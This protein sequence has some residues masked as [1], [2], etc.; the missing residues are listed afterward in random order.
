M[1]EDHGAEVQGD[2]INVGDEL[3][4]NLKENKSMNWQFVSKKRAIKEVEYGNYY[5]VIVIPEDFSE[6]LASVER[7][8]KKQQWNTM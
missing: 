8:P 3:V 1:N 2:A 5:A 7:Q 6:Q 4:D